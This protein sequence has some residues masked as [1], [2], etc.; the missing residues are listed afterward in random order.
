MRLFPGFLAKPV[1][2]PGPSVV[3]L[4]G[5]G[6]H[7]FELRLTGVQVKVSLEHLSS[8]GEPLSSIPNIKEKDKQNALS[9]KKDEKVIQ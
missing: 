8:M 2:S 3:V 1:I 9:L 4:M 5:C 6:P 7:C